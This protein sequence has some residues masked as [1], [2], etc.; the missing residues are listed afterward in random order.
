M[1]GPRLPAGRRVTEGEIS[2]QMSPASS[3]GQ[4]TVRTAAAGRK[5]GSSRAGRSGSTGQQTAYYSWPAR[6]EA[7]AKLHKRLE[8]EDR[9]RRLIRPN[10]DDPSTNVDHMAY[11][12]GLSAPQGPIKAT[13]W[14][15]GPSWNFPRIYSGKPNVRLCIDIRI[16]FTPEAEPCDDLTRLVKGLAQNHNRQVPSTHARINERLLTEKSLCKASIRRKW[17]V[18]NQEYPW[19][20]ISGMPPPFR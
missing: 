7:G 9:P 15:P 17:A 13:E 12:N 14:V 2:S 4:P 19:T 1:S 16:I 6:T 20:A 3:S 11:G 18:V 10:T 8:V 5:D